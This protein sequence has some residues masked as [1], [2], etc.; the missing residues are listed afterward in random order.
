MGHDDHTRPALENESFQIRSKPFGCRSIERGKRLVQ[1]DNSRS[2]Q[3]GA[4]NCGALEQTPAESQGQFRRPVTQSRGLQRR[5]SNSIGLVER[6]EA[7][8]KGQVFRE[9]EVVVEQ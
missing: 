8:S 2:V 5:I 9:D 7:G 4:G 6:I 1:Q 3:Q